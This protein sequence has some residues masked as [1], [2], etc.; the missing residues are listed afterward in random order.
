VEVNLQIP[1]HR[2]HELMDT[3]CNLVG[4]LLDI[5]LP[6]RRLFP[7]F[8]FCDARILAWQPS[9]ASAVKAVEEYGRERESSST[10]M[11][12]PGPDNST[13]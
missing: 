3:V 11:K 13:Q 4:P 8:Y 2:I 5:C 12:L 6:E 9:R 10:T 7:L 1:C